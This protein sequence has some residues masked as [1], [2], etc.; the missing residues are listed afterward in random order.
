MP[1]GANYFQATDAFDR[2]PQ[3]RGPELSFLT[4]VWFSVLPT[5]RTSPRPP[6]ASLAAPNYAGVGPI[7]SSAMRRKL[8]KSYRILWFLQQR[9]VDAAWLG[10]AQRALAGALRSGKDW[11]FE[12]GHIMND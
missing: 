6:A 12:V 3:P 4:S 8:V 5:F 11:N 10:D 7:V 9:P 2:R 1:P